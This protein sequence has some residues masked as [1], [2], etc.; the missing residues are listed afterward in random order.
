LLPNRP[1][2]ALDAGEEGR[3]AT[4]L[5]P[6]LD[7]GSEN[8]LETYRELE[9]DRRLRRDDARAVQDFSRENE[10]NCRPVFEHSRPSV[11][12]PTCA[13]GALA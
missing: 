5:Q 6:L 8:D 11:F 12:L 10:K 3:I 1:G 9:A 13:L 7:Q 4:A 2:L